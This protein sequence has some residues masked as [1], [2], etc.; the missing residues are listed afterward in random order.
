MAAAGEDPRA[1]A[2]DA[3]ARR[4]LRQKAVTWLGKELNRQRKQL[5]KG[6]PADR[7]AVAKALAYWKEDGWLAAVR[8]AAA[9]AELPADEQQACRKLWADVNEL[10]KQTA[11]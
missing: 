7:A 9:L 6:V 10:A 4:S 5:A 1:S 8:D 3:A 11:K 2:L